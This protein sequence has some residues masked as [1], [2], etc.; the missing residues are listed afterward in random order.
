MR[1]PDVLMIIIPRH[2]QRCAA[3]FFV[4][5]CAVCAAPRAEAQDYLGATFLPLSMHPGNQTHMAKYYD[6]K[7]DPRALFIFTPGAGVSYDRSASSPLISHIRYQ[8]L[9]MSDC[10]GMPAGY[11]S[12]GGVIPLYTGRSFLLA[13]HLGAGVFIRENWIY[14]KARERS[15][16]LW[17][18]GRAEWILGPYPELECRFIPE[19]VRTQIAVSFF[20]V[21]YVSTL[22]FRFL[23]PI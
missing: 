8:A 16:L 15:T 10:I 13:F 19:E 12:A 17:D 4:F 11:V 9:V 3:A 21:V 6:R 5:L 7:L 1:F 14:S 20:S 23:I 18:A 22:S 2:A